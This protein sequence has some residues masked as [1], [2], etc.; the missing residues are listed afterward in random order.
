MKNILILILIELLFSKLIYAYDK[1]IDGLIYLKNESVLKVVLKIPI[2]QSQK[3]VYEKVQYQIKYIDANGILQKLRPEQIKEVRFKFNN[4]D[5]RMLS[6]VDN[7]K[8]NGGFSS[9]KSILL[10]LETYGRMNHFLFYGKST[11]IEYDYI[12]GPLNVLQIDNGELFVPS[13]FNDFKKINKYIAEC[14]SL[15]EKINNEVYNSEN[16]KEIVKDFNDCK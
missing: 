2:Y 12:S 5:I 4:E 14:P 9:N 3:I 1:D 15:V 13:W 10:K 7:V 16:I 6:L 8:L 11:Y